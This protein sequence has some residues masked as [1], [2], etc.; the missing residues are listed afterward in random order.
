[1]R[2]NIPNSRALKPV[3]RA[4][5]GNATRIAMVITGTRSRYAYIK[6]TAILAEVVFTT[7]VRAAFSNLPTMVDLLL[8][9]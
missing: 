2:S 6:Q 9:A 8:P 7:I 4:A 3:Q 5:I 1:V